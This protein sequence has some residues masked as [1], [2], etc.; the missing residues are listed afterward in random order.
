MH[1]AQRIFEYGDKN[2][3][4]LAILAKGWVTSTH[5]VGVQDVQG[6]L[7][8]SPEGINARFSEFFQEMYSIYGRSYAVLGLLPIS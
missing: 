5:I 3:Q 2:S 6:S 7:L 4:L 1:P 8:T